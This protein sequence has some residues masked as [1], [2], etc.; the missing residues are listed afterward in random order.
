MRLLNIRLLDLAGVVFA[1]N[2]CNRVADARRVRLEYR[3]LRELSPIRGWVERQFATLTGLAYDLTHA[4][5]FGVRQKTCW[6]VR[7]QW[8]FHSWR[9]YAPTC[10]L[11]A[12]SGSIRRFRLRQPSGG[13]TTKTNG[14]LCSP[15]RS[16]FRNAISSSCWTS[17]RPVKRF[18][19]GAA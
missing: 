4:N 1:F 14:R 18:A 19:D 12:R 11:D 8:F 6:K 2:T 15:N 9:T 16:V 10:Q 5:G 17:E 13:E 7:G 3:F